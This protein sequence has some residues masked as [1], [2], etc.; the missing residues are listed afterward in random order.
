MTLTVLVTLDLLSVGGG[1][2][3]LGA[4]SSVKTGTGDLLELSGAV[5]ERGDFIGICCSLLQ[6]SVGT[7]VRSAVCSSGA[8]SPSRLVAFSDLCVLS[9]NDLSVA[10]SAGGIGGR[11]GAA[12]W[13]RYL[14]QRSRQDCHG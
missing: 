7:P 2:W 5:A 10:W 3:L 11:G 6:C 8:F 4:C 13:L 14:T 12:L 9:C 1:D